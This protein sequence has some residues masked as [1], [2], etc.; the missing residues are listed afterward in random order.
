MHAWNWSLSKDKACICSYF[1]PLL[2]LLP[3]RGLLL[4]K[5]TNRGAAS[6]LLNVEKFMSSHVDGEG[7]RGECKWGWVETVP[8]QVLHLQATCMPCPTL[9]VSLILATCATLNLLSCIC[10]AQATCN[11][12]KLLQNIWQRPRPIPLLLPPCT[13]RAPEAHILFLSLSLWSCSVLASPLCLPQSQMTASWL[14]SMYHAPHSWH[15]FTL[16]FCG[17]MM[18]QLYVRYYSPPPSILSPLRAQSHAMANFYTALQWN[19]TFMQGEKKW[20]QRKKAAA[21]IKLDWKIF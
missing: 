7:G 18:R 19:F 16:P 4:A 12:L 5:A 9:H 21:S 8:E 15:S 17:L 20:K 1:I 13:P 3:L 14:S 2:L 10:L 11:M 6:R